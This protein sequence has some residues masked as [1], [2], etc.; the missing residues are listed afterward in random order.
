LMQSNL[1]QAQFMGDAK[2]PVRNG[3]IGMIDRFTV[4]VTNQLPR[5]AAAG[6]TWVSGNGSETTKTIAANAAARRTLVAGHKSAIAFA[7]QM[8]KTE[9]LRNPTDF[10]DLVRGLQIFGHK[11]VQ[12]KAL[13]YAVVA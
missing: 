12:G 10:G 11:V 2:S 6:T 8:A 7:S 9:T 5:A 3:M 4:Y 13:T 1:A